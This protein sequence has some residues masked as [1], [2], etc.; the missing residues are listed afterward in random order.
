MKG[1]K[2]EQWKN[3][4]KEKKDQRMKAVKEMI[5]GKSASANL[6]VD[7]LARKTGINRRTLYLRKSHPETIRLEELW[8]I[9]DVLKP[10]EFYLE[11]II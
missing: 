3:L 10:E 5:N 9:I 8:A 7:E 2:I 4:K 1:A 11:K 6:T